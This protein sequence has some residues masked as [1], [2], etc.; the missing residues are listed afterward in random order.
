M[1]DT[2]S[3]SA[4]LDTLIPTTH[5][6]WAEANFKATLLDLA[7][8]FSLKRVLEIGGGR[9]PSFA[10]EE[11]AAAG[12]E[13]SISDISESELALADA[14]YGKHCFDIG[15]ASVPLE[16]GQYDLIFSCK[17]FE[18]VANAEQAYRNAAA[19][20]APGGVLVNF[21]PVLFS[22]PMVINQLLPEKLAAAVL[23]FYRPERNPNQQPKFPS[24]YRLC[25]ANAATSARIKACGFEEVCI[26]EFYGHHYF[27]RVP[28]LKHT[29][30]FFTALCQRFA[31]KALASRTYI[32]ARKASTPHNNG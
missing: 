7:Q 3:L 1:R 11:V 10:V 30:A 31:V 19:L 28:I 18:H 26:K 16:S 17:V 9:R 22:P 14:R 13:Y 20:L 25:R 23:R 5:C 15:G 6:D 32:A 24:F 4:R 27:D 12:L 21:V 29:H 8:H 2:P